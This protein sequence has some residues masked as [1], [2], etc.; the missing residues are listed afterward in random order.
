MLHGSWLALIR[1]LPAGTTYADRLTVSAKMGARRL[2]V[3]CLSLICG[4]A[5]LWLLDE[6]SWS[7]VVAGA[8]L[9][10][11]V[12]AT[13][14]AVGSYRRHSDTSRRVRRLP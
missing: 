2:A 14:W 8:L 13:I 6:T 3:G 4:L 9:A 1:L 7:E 12:S 11:S 10:W 5:A